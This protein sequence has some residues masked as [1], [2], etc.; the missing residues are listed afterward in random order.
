[1]RD[2][3]CC[4]PSNKMMKNGGKG[5][6]TFKPRP[7]RPL[8]RKSICMTLDAT[9]LHH[10]YLEKEVPDLTDEVVSIAGVYF[11]CVKEHVFFL[12]PSIDLIPLDIFKVMKG[13]AIMDEDTMTSP[14]PEEGA[15]RKGSEHES[16]QQEHVVM[17]EEP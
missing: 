10:K 15:A 13:R 11:K 16:P 12:Y 14:E 3:N 5:W 9:L 8:L 7:W 4:S 17:E 1:M 6:R 2:N